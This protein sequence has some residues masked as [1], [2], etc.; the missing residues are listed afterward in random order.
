MQIQVYLSTGIPIKFVRTLK[1]VRVKERSRAC[2]ECELTSKD[3]TLYWK[4][5]GRLLERSTKYS[6]SHEGK[7]AEL[8]IE[9]AQLS[10]SGEYTVVAMQDGDPTEYY[11]T[12]VVTVEGTC[13]PCQLPLTNP[14]SPGGSLPWT[15]ISPLLT[16]ASSNHGQFLLPSLITPIY[17]ILTLSDLPGPEHLYLLDPGHTPCLEPYPKSL[18]F[19]HPLL[20]DSDHPQQP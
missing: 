3:V 8:V 2:L 9:D 7:R 14:P 12:A 19:I 20:P 18:D 6:M 5:D 11:S 15:L 16:P 10:D 13:S 17:Q 4:K 1:N